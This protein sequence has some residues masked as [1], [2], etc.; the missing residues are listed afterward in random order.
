MKQPS[1]PSGDLLRVTVQ[2]GNRKYEQDLGLD[3]QAPVDLQGLN[4]ALAAHPGKFAWWG[5]LEVL[6]RAQYEELESTLKR[7][8]A[9]LFTA[10]SARLAAAPPPAEKEGKR[11]RQGA[12]LDAIKARVAVDR[13]RVA[14]AERV[15]R[16]KLD[17]EQLMVGRQ[18]MLQRRDT[19]LA[20]ASNMRAEMDANLSVRARHAY[21]AGSR[22]PGAPLSK[23]A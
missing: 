2:L 19:L 3:A 17:Y 5:M 1:T 21:P 15:A 12:T 13:E 20:I 22:A 4:D 7:L 18:T 8:E 6:A 14:L 16:A 11:P 10:Y 9:E 23:G